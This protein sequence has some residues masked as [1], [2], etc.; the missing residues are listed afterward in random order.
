MQVKNHFYKLLPSL[1]IILALT[2]CRKDFLNPEEQDGVLLREQ[3]VVDLKTTNEYLKGTY[4]ALS[5]NVFE[6]YHSIYPDLIADNVKPRLA[7]SGSTPM[8]NQYNW[9]Q[10][11]NNLQASLR[12]ALNCNSMSYACYRVVNYAN[13]VI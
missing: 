3:Y 10:F 2:S 12:N 11:A 4:A 8:I 5:I 7:A 9:T 1:I 6:S 13:F